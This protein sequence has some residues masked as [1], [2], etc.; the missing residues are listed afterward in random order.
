MQAKQP[1]WIPSDERKERANITR[2]I[3]YVNKRFGLEIVGYQALHVWSV[4]N[5]ESFWEA[6][7]EFM[8]IIASKPWTRVL[9]DETKMPG[10]T[11]F[12]GAELNF[13]ENMLR[14][15]DD[16]DALVFKGEGQAVTRMSYAELYSQVERLAS[17]LRAAGV[18]KGERIA[19]FMPNLPQTVVAMLAA[20]SLGAVWSS[21]SPDFGVKGVLD[22]FGQIEPKVLF[23]ADGYIYNGKTHDSLARVQSILAELPSIERVVVVPYTSAAPDLT[24]IPNATLWDAFLADDPEPLSFTQVPFDHPLY[25]MYSSGTTG[26][27]K[28]MVQSVGGI[29]LHQL[30]EQI[31]HTDLTRDDSIFYYTTCGWMMWNWLVSSLAVGATVVLF[32]GAPFYPGPEALW[33]LAAEEKISVFGVSAK[34]IAVLEKQAYPVGERHELPALRSIL[35][36]GSPLAPESYDYVYRDVKADVQLSSISGGSDLN[37]CFA[38]GNELLP[39][40]RGELQGSALAMDV[41]AFDPEGKPVVGAQ[42]ELVCRKPFPSMPIYFWSDPDG[43]KYCKAYFESFPGVWHHGDFVEVTENGGL[44]ITGRSDATLNPGGVRIGTADIYAVV[45]TFPE[46]DDSLV[47]GQNW[48]DDVRII[49]FVKLADGRAFDADLETRIKRS[50]RA[51]ASVRH[52]PAKVIPIDDIPYTI[53]MKK[54]EIAVRKVIHGQPITNRDALRNPEALDLYKDLPQLKS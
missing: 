43:E 52:V 40:F 13:A 45:E 7:W 27:P 51:N 21:S 16:R 5:L 42:G 19:G 3:A 32:D 29:L 35:S 8:G 28:C 48:Q 46:V 44:I 22:R 11:W 17:A 36:T 33:E 39:V 10:A 9:D 24:G 54:V 18:K 12:E 37:G 41:A 30:K 31:L 49:L 1:L 14:F 20:T 50:I 53:S 23:T 47:V 26:L 34:Y 38:C 4:T 25:I 6:A 2:F 15:R